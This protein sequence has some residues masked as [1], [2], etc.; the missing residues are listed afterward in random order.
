MFHLCSICS[1]KGVPFDLFVKN[2]R[3]DEEGS[4]SYS[5]AGGCWEGQAPKSFHA[6]IRLCRNLV[7]RGNDAVRR[8]VMRHVADAIE[9]DK[10]AV[11][12]L[13]G[14]RACMDIR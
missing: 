3:L 10:L 4:E 6:V 11:G 1:T 9:H 14:E 7:D 12:Q 2:E 5:P 13:G 8:H